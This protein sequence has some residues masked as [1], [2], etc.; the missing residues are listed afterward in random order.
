MVSKRASWAWAVSALAI[1]VSFSPF[2]SSYADNVLLKVKFARDLGVADPAA[3][4][5]ITVHLRMADPAG[6]DRT[7]QALDNPALASFHHWL[8]DAQLR[9]FAPSARA[10]PAVRGALEGGGLSIVSSD[11]NGFLIRAC[12]TVGRVSWLF[13]TPI[14]DFMG[15]VEVYHTNTRTAALAGEAGAHLYA[16]AGLEATPYGRW[17]RLDVPMPPSHGR[18][19]RTGTICPRSRPVRGYGRTRPA[20]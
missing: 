9:R 11:R 14:L 18:R 17:H 3:K 13:Q 1:A 19:W 8:T 2:A 16:V 6:L 4:I 5:T 10:V 20:S 12:G 15:R 7:L